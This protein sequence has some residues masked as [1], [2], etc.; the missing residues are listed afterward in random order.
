V[1]VLYDLVSKEVAQGMVLVVKAESGILK[2]TLN[3]ETILLL[4]L[5]RLG[6]HFNVGHFSDLI[7][8]FNKW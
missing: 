7:I 2:V 5:D 8:S 1:L 6:L 4:N 3:F